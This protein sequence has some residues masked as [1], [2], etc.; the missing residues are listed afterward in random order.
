MRKVYGSLEYARLTQIKSGL[1]CEI[2]ISYTKIP[3]SRKF[4]LFYLILCHL[5]TENFLTYRCAVKIPWMN[6]WSFMILEYIV[7]VQDINISSLTYLTLA[8]FAI[9]FDTAVFQ[10]GNWGNV[11]LHSSGL[12]LCPPPQSRAEFIL[13]MGHQ[14]KEYSE[15]LHKPSPPL[16]W[17]HRCE[18]PK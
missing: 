18:P 16:L 9:P 6:E 8:S 7:T 1:F 12:Q 4:C 2:G 13:T 15:Q 5:N 17:K 10:R 11:L 3:K 14:T